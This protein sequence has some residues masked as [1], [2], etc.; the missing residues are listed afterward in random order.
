MKYHQCLPR[1]DKLCQCVKTVKLY[2]H[3]WRGP[4]CAWFF[5]ARN[6]GKMD[7]EW[8]PDFTN[9]LPTT[10]RAIPA[11]V[12]DI[13]TFVAPLRASGNTPAIWKDDPFLQWLIRRRCDILG[14]RLKKVVV[15]RLVLGRL[16]PP[17]FVPNYLLYMNVLNETIPSFVCQSLLMSSFGSL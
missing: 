14:Y 16:C 5:N 17:Y 8:H 3:A 9:C 10:K 2:S 15:P 11:W 7:L 12:K 6:K 4:G 1:G 13:V